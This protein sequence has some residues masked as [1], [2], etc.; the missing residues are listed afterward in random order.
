MP[1]IP[2]QTLTAA[3]LRTGECVL[4]KLDSVPMPE[5]IVVED[6]PATDRGQGE[7]VVALGCP[8]RGA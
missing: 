6:V 1:V 2:T 8:L 7:L 3:L 5:T 4:G